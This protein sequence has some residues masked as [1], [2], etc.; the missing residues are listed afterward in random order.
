MDRC[1]LAKDIGERIKQARNALKMM[2]KD[3]CLRIDMPLPSLSNY[4]LGKRIPGGE[5]LISFTNA[6]IN[7]HWLLTGEGDMFQA[8]AIARTANNHP[9]GFR[10]MM[11]GLPPLYASPE[12]DQYRP[13]FALIPLYDVEASAGSGS[14]IEQEPM[15]YQMAFRKDWLSQKG[16]QPTNCALIKAKGDSMEP[17]IHDGDLLLIDTRIDSIKDD[18]LYIVQA[19]HHLIVKR[20]QQDWDGSLI[21][22]SDNPRYEKR[23]ISPEQAK[24]V[25]IA[26]RVRWY[27]HEI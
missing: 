15:L 13:D 23:I 12:E 10:K 25:K 16:L 4:E 5:A 26:G 11:G 22:I 24:E 6:G 21:V 19:D 1:N 2:Q 7:A 17:T 27:G 9:E 20:I 14:L 3:F 18:S 8:D